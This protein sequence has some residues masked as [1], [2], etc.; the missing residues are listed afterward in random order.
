[1]EEKMAILKKYSKQQLVDLEKEAKARF[2]QR[3]E[4]YARDR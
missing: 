3:L 1:M 2:E 4:E